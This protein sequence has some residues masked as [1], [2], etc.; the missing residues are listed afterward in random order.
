[1]HFI[2]F[3]Q[4]SDCSKSRV[5]LLSNNYY[6]FSG[7]LFTAGVLSYGVYNF[8]K[9]RSAMS[10]KMMRLRVAAQGAT[11]FA[12]VFGVMYKYQE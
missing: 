10:Q 3:P 5:Y 2:H 1:M 11:L 6:L 12:I 7:C 8:S 9:G 4:C